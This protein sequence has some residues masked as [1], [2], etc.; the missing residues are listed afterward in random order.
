MVKY[1]EGNVSNKVPLFGMKLIGEFRIPG[2]PRTS[3]FFARKRG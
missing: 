2:R 1:F 3:A